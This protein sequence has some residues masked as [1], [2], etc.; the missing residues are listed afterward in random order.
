MKNPFLNLGSNPFNLTPE[1]KYYPFKSQE[2]H[3]AAF[4][5]TMDSILPF[6]GGGLNG[7]RAALIYL[8][9]I[10]GLEAAQTMFE[11]MKASVIKYI[12]RAMGVVL[13]SLDGEALLKAGGEAAAKTFKKQVFK[14]YGI[15]CPI[16]NFYSDT[17]IE[18]LGEWLADIINQQIK[19]HAHVETEVFT[20]IFPYENIVSELDVF[21]SDEIGKR[22]GFVL[23]GVIT[24][25]N[26]KDELQAGVTDRIKTQFM[27]GVQTQINASVN[28][29]KAQFFNFSA[30]GEIVTIRGVNFSRVQAEVV[31]GFVETAMTQGLTKLQTNITQLNPILGYGAALSGFY[32]D[33]KKI[34]NRLRQREFRRTH[35]EVRQWQPR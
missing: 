28:Q 24:N 6:A 20:T 5:D 2:E 27:E 17:I 29:V 8:Q 15:D 35:R 7:A 19:T 1:Q 14:K 11:N 34:N 18:E 26:L 21:L 9:R 16:V 33:R 31:F 4:Q 23:N 10:A 3:D 32:A 30:G 22:M 25:P 12:S 13:E